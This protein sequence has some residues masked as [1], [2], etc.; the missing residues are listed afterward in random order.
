MDIYQR[1]MKGA[2]FLDTMLQNALVDMHAKCGST[3]K[4]RELFDRIPQR[5]VITHN[6]QLD[7]TICT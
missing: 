1:K 5:D 6:T 4:E 2:F 3:N 7:T